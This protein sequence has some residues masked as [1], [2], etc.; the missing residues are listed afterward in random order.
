MQINNEHLCAPMSGDVLCADAR[1]RGRDGRGGG[2]S[3]EKNCVYDLSNGFVSSYV[4]AHL[5]IST[6]RQYKV[7][8]RYLRDSE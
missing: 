5:P 7:L 1:L 8:S 6:H 4:F 3:R 2:G